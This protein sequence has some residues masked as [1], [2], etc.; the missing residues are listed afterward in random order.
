M[1]KNIRDIAKSAGVSVT[2][3][4]KVINN[5]PSVSSKTKER[6]LQIIRDER[7]IPSHT[8]RGLV[9]GRSKTLGIFLTTG[10]SHP[11]FS[12]V[13]VGMEDALKQTGYDLM[14]LA[15]ID[16]SPEYSL[17]RHALSR[18]VEGVLI[19]GFHKHDLNFDEM[20]QSEIPTVFIDMDMIGIRAGFV[21]S[22]N[23]ESIKVAV[24]YLHELKHRKI[25]FLSGQLDS[26]VGK[27]RFEGYRQAIHELGLPYLSE[28]IATGDFTKASGYKAMKAFLQLKEPPTAVVCSSDM[29]AVGVMEAAKEAGL[30]VPNDLS[31]IGFDDIE[32]AKH[33]QPALTTTHQDFHTIGYQS[34]LMLNDMIN[35]PNV[36]PPALV[37]PTT[38]AV[39]ESCAICSEEAV[40]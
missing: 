27:L 34:V 13:M 14:Y 9:K 40:Q 8:A 25:A 30:S 2:T 20:I 6:V 29:G 5:H 24:R 7:F 28:Y 4:S 19:F 23:V 17:V 39:R 38:F 10:L 35:S 18:N 21:T 11:F 12:N 36:P 16:W 37:V 31:V 26:Y 22:D 32:L 1:A 3:V 33:M 15:Q